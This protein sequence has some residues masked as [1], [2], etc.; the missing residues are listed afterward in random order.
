M[1][2]IDDEPVYRKSDCGMFWEFPQLKTTNANGKPTNWNVKVGVVDGKTGAEMHVPDEGPS[3]VPSQHHGVVHVTS[4]QDGG[5]VRVGV[6]ELIT[7]GKNLGRSNE[8]TPVVQAVKSATSDWKKQAKKYGINEHNQDVDIAAR[9]KPCLPNESGKTSRANLTATDYRRGVVVQQK[10]DGVNGQSNVDDAGTVVHWGR[11]GGV[12]SLPHLDA[13]LAAAYQHR[14]AFDADTLKYMGVPATPENITA[15]RNVVPVLNYELYNHNLNDSLRVISG[16]ARKKTPP[17]NGDFGDG[18]P[19]Q[20]HIFDVHF[21]LAKARGI[22]ATFE[23]RAK[24]LELWARNPAA[25]ILHPAFEDTTKAY[26]DL[27]QVI[28]WKTSHHAEEIEAEYE[29]SLNEKYEGLVLKRPTALYVYSDNNK[30]SSDYIKK[31]PHGDS[32]FNIVGYEAGT[33]TDAGAVIWVCETPPDAAGKKHR[34]SVRPKGE[35]PERRLIYDSLEKP[36][37]EDPSKTVFETEYKDK[38]YTVVYFKIS[39]KTGIPM[40]PRGKA[41][42]LVG[43]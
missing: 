6:P 41:M 26:E 11:S 13:P 21:P 30:H 23:Q 25:G 9:P 24:Y 38:P 18:F 36:S 43:T 10:R 14:P 7:R 39:D 1:A 31:K 16:R 19:L 15:F 40:Q 28:P 34:F 37:E 3:A 4:G 20:A 32:E 42:R 22:H 27:L 35:V 17:A 29:R 33:G 12:V 5:K 2:A 8:T